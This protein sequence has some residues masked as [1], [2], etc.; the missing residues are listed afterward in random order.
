MEFDEF[1]KLEGCTTKD[2][3]VFIGKGKNTD[4]EE[5]VD[6]VRLVKLIGPEAKR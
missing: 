2:R 4:K 6:T 1:L 5:K 3:H